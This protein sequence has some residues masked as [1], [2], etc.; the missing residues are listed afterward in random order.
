MGQNPYLRLYPHDIFFDLREFLVKCWYSVSNSLFDAL[1]IPSVRAPMGQDD[2]AMHEKEWHGFYSVYVNVIPYLFTHQFNSLNR[3]PYYNFF[4]SQKISL[5]NSSSYKFNK[6]HWK[7]IDTWLLGK[8][9]YPFHAR[10]ERII[11][12][13]MF[14]GKRTYK[15]GPSKFFSNKYYKF[16]GKNRKSFRFSSN[17]NLKSF[18]KVVKS[19]NKGIYKFNNELFSDPL[20]L[21]L[22]RYKGFSKLENL[23]KV[24]NGFNFFNKYKFLG[25]SNKNLRSFLNISSSPGVP[26]RSIN[27]HMSRKQRDFKLMRNYMKNFYRAEMFCSL[28]PIYLTPPPN[29]GFPGVKP[30]FLHMDYHTLFMYPDIKFLGQG[31]NRV[32]ANRYR[33]RNISL[34]LKFKRYQ[35]FFLP[36]FNDFNDDIYERSFSFISRKKNLY[37]ENFF[38]FNKFIALN[39]KL[40]IPFNSIKSKKNVYSLYERSVYDRHLRFSGKS[41]SFFNKFNSDKIY[42]DHLTSSFFNKKIFDSNFSVF[43]S[44]FY[45]SFKHFFLFNPNY[46]LSDSNTF[47]KL[48]YGSLRLFLS[49]YPSLALDRSLI[50]FLD[51]QHNYAVNLNLFYKNLV[52]DRANNVVELRGSATILSNILLKSSSTSSFFKKYERYNILNSW[53]LNLL[54][55]FLQL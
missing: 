43:K 18:N 19:Q 36:Q 54:I 28:R 11:P 7:I 51:S 46:I 49:S 29:E 25:L 50:K 41:I 38:F 53:I 34:Y 9:R 48:N 32:T 37:H 2:L 12:S 30:E 42:L 16:S 5:L 13:Y 6:I 39:G 26:S 31:T 47:N 4:N 17:E 20:F 27:R 15:I 3:I 35:P 55:I 1:W 44:K 45:K 40:L 21:L 10:G 52:K 33:E 22:F 14:K 24:R 23:T 8:L